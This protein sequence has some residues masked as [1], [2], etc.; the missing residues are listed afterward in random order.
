M[1]GHI[2]SERES[3]KGSLSRGLQGIVIILLLARSYFPPESISYRT[4]GRVG[5]NSGT[6]EMLMTSLGRCNANTF[7][8]SPLHCSKLWY[9]SPQHHSWPHVVMGVYC[10]QSLRQAYNLLYTSAKT[11]WFLLT[12]EFIRSIT[13]IRFTWCPKIT[14]AL[15]QLT[16]Q[17]MYQKFE[18]RSLTWEFCDVLI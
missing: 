2:L 10:S 4:V 6:Q 14:L 15:W 5:E 18:R 8:F 17:G 16:T 12:V 9:H 3:C 13:L 7:S 11:N 1:F